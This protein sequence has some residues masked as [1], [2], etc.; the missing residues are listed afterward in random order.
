MSKMEYAD[1]IASAR[2]NSASEIQRIRNEAAQMVEDARNKAQSE[3]NRTAEEVVETKKSASDQ[4]FESPG[5]PGSRN[6]SSPRKKRPGKRKTC[7]PIGRSKEKNC[8]RTS[9]SPGKKCL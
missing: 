4:I 3:Q 5:G 9:P 1:E 6:C 7:L 2:E 8:R